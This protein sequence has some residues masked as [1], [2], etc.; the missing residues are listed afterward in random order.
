VLPEP[1][2]SDPPEVAPVVEPPPPV[3]D[4]APPSL[5]LPLLPVPELKVP[6]PPQA[7]SDSIAATVA[8]IN[9]ART[10]RFAV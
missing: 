6:E 2:P 3:V 1:D 8:A 9:V 4:S 7:L 10:V 5:P